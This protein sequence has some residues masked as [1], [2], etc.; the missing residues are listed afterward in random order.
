MRKSRRVARRA[1]KLEQAAVNRWGPIS[2]FPGPHGTHGMQGTPIQASL[3]TRRNLC[4]VR[5]E[6]MDA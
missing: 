5:L 1:R 2:R 6:Q 3:E 4:L